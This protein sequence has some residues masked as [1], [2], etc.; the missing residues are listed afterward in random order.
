MVNFYL[1]RDSRGQMLEETKDRNGFP[2]Y[3]KEEWKD[4]I[5]IFIMGIYRICCDVSSLI[6]LYSIASVVI[7][8]G[9]NL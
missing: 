1:G 7:E 8:N 5:N 9:L 2:R 4:P 6:I 3:E